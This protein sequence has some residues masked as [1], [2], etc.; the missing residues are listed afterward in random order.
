MSAAMPESEVREQAQAGSEPPTDHVE[1]AAPRALAP[2][3]PAEALARRVWDEDGMLDPERLAAVEAELI[4][5]KA[6]ATLAG[7]LASAAERASDPE[8]G[9]RT[10]T[11]AGHM[12][13]DDVKDPRRGAAL[14]QRV[15]ASDPLAPEAL[16]GLVRACLAD[17]RHEEAADVMERLVQALPD[18]EKVPVLVELAD[19]AARLDQVDRAL[20]A[21]RF[22]YELDPSRWD[23]LERARG[24]FEAEGR[25]EDAQQV[26]DDQT[27]AL[28]GDE[29]LESPEVLAGRV[30]EV[31]E[32]AEGAPEGS[33]QVEVGAMVSRLAA[34]YHGLGEALL[35]SAL[36]H[37]LAEIC[38]LTARSLGDEAALSLLDELASLRK[39]WEAR[40]TALRDRGFEAPQKQKAA[41]LYL[42]AAELFARYGQDALRADEYL[43]RCLILVP[44]YPPALR[45]LEAVHRGQGR[46]G[47]LVKRLNGMAAQVKDP[48][49]RADILLRVAQLTEAGLAEGEAPEP[50]QIEA[51]VNAYRRLLAHQPGHREAVA[52]L[53]DILSE[54]QRPADLA[55]VLEGHLAALSEPYQKVRVHLEL[56]RIYA[57]Q[58]GDSGRARN[59]FEAVLSLRPRDFV[60][61]SALRA[62]YKDAREAPLLLGVQKVL[63]E[64]CPD[65]FSRLELLAEMAE[66][67]E[68][69][70]PDEAFSVARAAFEL[71]P[72]ANGARARLEA[73]AEKLGRF[74]ALAETFASA[75][76]RRAGP[77]AEALWM[78]AGRLFDSKLPRPQDAIR[79]FRE[80][81]RENQGNAEATEA[82]ERL[83]RQQDDPEALVE[84]LR[85]QLAGSEDPEQQRI[86]RSKVGEVLAGRLGDLEGAIECFEAV[87]A[88]APDDP[89]ALAS[90]DDL[91]G[92][93]ERY[94]A[95]AQILDRRAQLADSDAERAE[96]LCRRAKLFDE[97]L[98]D[99]EKAVELYLEVLEAHPDHG[100]PVPA[101]ADLLERGV[102]RAPIAAALEPA[103][104]RR[105]QPDR[106]LVM[107]EVQLEGV[108]G[109]ARA[110][111]A[112]KAARVAE[113]R[114]DDR[115][116]ALT[117]L[118]TAVEVAASDEA[119][120]DR[121]IEVARAEA[122]PEEAAQALARGLD[123]GV[124][125]G[126]VKSR[127]AG[128]LAELLE[129]D[130]SDLDGAI[131]RYRE[132][133][134]ADGSNAS[135]IA[136]LERLLGAEAR[137]AELAELLEQRIAATD[138]PAAKVQLGLSV[139]GL[140]DEHLDDREGAIAALEAVLLVAPEDATALGR[141]A[142]LLEAAGHHRKLVGVLDRLR[143]GSADPELRAQSE[144]RAGDVLRAN[145]S[146][147]AEALARY[148]RALALSPN[149]AAAV[150]GLEALLDNEAHRTKAG[151]L[152][153]P[154]YEAAERWPD[155]VLAL[156]SQLAGRVDKAERASLFS[157][158]A[159]IEAEKLDQASSAFETLSRA[160]REGLL[161]EAQADRMA[162]LAQQS[163]K[164]RE[165]ARLYEDARP[166]H[167]D[168]AG[169]LRALARLYDG[170]AADPAKAR[171][172]Y[173]A[174]LEV[175]PGDAEALEALERLTAAGD[176]PAELGRVLEKRAEA[177]EA[178]PDRVTF[179]KR[180]AAIYEEAAEDIDAAIR[181][182]EA[183]RAVAPDDVGA[184]SEL[185]RFY[186]ARGDAEALEGVLGALVERT[187][188]PR[189]AANLLVRRA[190]ARKAQ[191]D[192][193]G[194]IEDLSAALAALPE[195]ADARAGLEDLLG[196]DAAPRAAL[197]LE[198][199][200]RAAGDWSR[201]VDAYEILV[202]SSEEPAE[203]VERLVA[204]RSIYEERL[205]QPAKAF[206]AAA[207]AYRQ[208]PA[209]E[210]LLAGL[211]RLG[212]MSGSVES[213]IAVL[214]DQAEE[215]PFVSEERAGLRLRVA[216]YVETLLQDRGRAVDAY[217]RALEE[218]PDSVAALEALERIYAK[219]GQHRELV[220]VLRKMAGILEDPARQ[221]ERL[222]L[223]ARIL[224]EQ[225]G[226][227]AQAA[228]LYEQVIMIEPG[229]GDALARL[230]A[231]YSQARAN[232]DLGRVLRLRIG[233]A[234]GAAQAAL[235]L[236]LGQ[237]SLAALDDPRGALEAYAGVL[238]IGEDV[239]QGAFDGAMY[240]LD[241]LI[242][243]VKDAN[244]ELAAE[245]A[246][247][248]EP[249]WAAK[250]QLAKVVG[251]K[252][253]QV[254]AAQDASTRKG[255]LV[256]IADL[257]DGQL[258]QAELAF[259]ALTRAYGEHP[260]DA[261]LVDRLEGLAERA[262]T[263]EELA[264]LFGHALPSIEDEALALRLAR[265][266]AHIYDQDL[267]R[268]DLAVPYYNWVLRLEPS[269]QGALAALE[270]I[271]HQQQDAAKLVDVYRG[272]LRA[273]EAP[274]TRKDLYGRIA[275]LLDSELQ[276]TDGAF[277]AYRAMLEV[278]PKDR[279]VLKRMAALC[280]RSDRFDELAAVLAKE[281]ELAE[282]SDDRAQVLLRLATVQRDRLEDPVSAVDTY[283]EVLGL[284][285]DDPGAISGL[286]AIVKSAG[287]GRADAAR[288]LA[289]VYK[290]TG[291]I[292]EYVDCLQLLVDASGDPMEKRDLLVEISE[293]YESRLGRPE[294]AF[295]YAQRALH[296]D[297]SHGAVRARLERLATENGQVEELAAF[298]LDEVEA[299]ED[300]ELALGLRRR[301][302]EIYDHE[303]GDVPRA[304]AEYGR[305]LDVAPG[306]R[307]SLMALERLY[308]AAGSFGAL[309]DVYRRR[310]AQSEDEEARAELLRQFARLQA[311][312]LGDA[313][314]AIASLRRLLELEPNDLEA[315]VK[316][317][318]LCKQQGRASE[319][320][321]VL[322]RVIETAEERSPVRLD[323]QLEL[324]RLKLDKLGDVAGAE[325]L[326]SAVLGEDPEH[327]ATR[328]LLQERFEDAVAE[329]DAARA[330]AFGG[331]LADALR[332]TED[333]QGLISVL[334]MRAEIMPRAPDRV[335]LEREVAEVYEQKLDQPELAFTTLAR[336]FAESPGLEEV[337]D[338][339]DRLA[340]RLLSY[341][342]L[343]DILQAGLPNAHD[344]E[345]AQ[346]IHRR[347]AQVLDEKLADKERAAEAW[348]VVLS[349]APMDAEGLA[350][351]DRLSEALGRWAAVA[352]VL[353]KRVE[354][355]EDGDARH[356]LCLRLGAVWDERLSEPEEALAWYRRARAEK[357]RDKEAL[358]ALSRLL[359]PEQHAQELFA[360]LE[361]LD[362]QAPDPRT[363]ARLKVRMADLAKGPL[364][365]AAEAV[366]LL[367]AVLLIDETNSKA[368]EGLE[369]LYEA[370]GHWT[371][372]AAL[373]ELQLE[374]AREEKEVVRLQRK[375][376]LIKGTRLGSV[377]EAVRSWSEILKRN[378]N[379]VEAL[380][381]LR[382]IYREAGRWEDLVA[383]LR[384]LVPLQLDAAGVKE[385][386]FELA[387]VFFEHLGD[388]DEAIESAKRVLDVEPHTASELMALEEILVRCGAYGE[389]VR[390]MNYRAEQAEG[391]GEKIEILFDIARVYEEK[392]GRLVGAAQAYEQV[393]ELEKTSTKAY[394]ALAGIYE[395]NGDYRRLVELYNRRL[396]V[397]EEAQAR[398]KLLFSI[399][400]IQERW[401]GHPELA[402]S[403]A[404]RAFGEEGAVEEAQRLAERLAEE[405]SNWEILAEV[406]EEQIEQV[407][408]SRAVQL[409]QRLAEI[410]LEKL[411]EPDEAEKQ[412]EMVLSMRPE[413]DS[414]RETLIRLFSEQER[415]SELIA[416]LTDKVELST[417]LEE[418]KHLFRRI[419]EIEETK[420]G[421]VEAAISSTKRV[422]DLDPEDDRALLE[423]SRIFRAHDKHHPLLNVLSRLLERAEDDATRVRL[424]MDVAAVWETGIED[425]D[426]A[427]EHYKDVLAL[428]AEHVPALKALE[429]LYT[430]L[431]RWIELVDVYERQVGLTTDS[432]EAIGLLTKIANIWE[433]QFRD[434]EGS[435][436]TLIR[437][438]EIDPEHLPTV[439]S[440]E[441]IWREAED[442]EHLIEAK[443]RHVELTKDPQEVVALQLE[444]GD[445]QL[446]YLERSDE[447]EQA[448][449]AALAKDPGSKAA[450]HALGQLY[451]K[452]GN[453]FN[454]LEM[455]SREAGLLG[456][457]PEAVEIHHRMGKINEEMLMDADAAKA[458]YARAL[459]IEPGYAPSIRAL[460]RMNEAEG[461]YEEVANLLAQEAQYSVDLEEQS[462]LY[463][464]SADLSLEH[465]DDEDQAIRLYDK[466]LEADPYFVPA[467]RIQGD[468]L[469]SREEW[470]Q[471]ESLLSRL[472]GRLD[473][474]ADAEELCRQYYRLAYIAE[475]LGDDHQ[476]LK[477]YLASYEIDSSY[478]PTLEGLGAALLR[479]E[480]WEDAQRIFQTILIQH[481][482]SLT[483]AEVVDLHWQIGELAA[484][485]S[486]LDKANKSFAK[487]L[488]LDPS[489]GPTL[490]ASAH[491]AERLED[492]EDAYDHRERLI[493]LLFG[494]ERFET[495]VEQAK[496]CEEKI[497]EPYRAIDAYM[498]ARRERPDDEQVLR[499]LAR[500]FDETGQVAQ[501]IEVLNDLG[502]VLAE[503][504]ERRDVYTQLADLHY[505]PEKNPKGAVTALNN[506]LDLDPMYI[507][508]FQR[509]EQIL[510]E[511]RDWRALEEN[512]HRM[513][514]RMPKEQ[515]KARLVL[516][517]SIGDL[518]AKVLKD[519]DGARVA[520]EVVLNKLDP[521]AHDVALELAE[522]Y[523]KKR[524]TAPKAITL[525]HRVL[526]KVEDPA[527]PARRLFELYHALGQLDRAFCALGALV[528]MRAATEDEVK[529]Y[530]LLL[531][532]A[533]P[534]P[535][536]SLSD[537]LWRSQVLHPHC[538]NGL[539]DILSVLYRG[540]PDM[541]AEPQQALRLGRRERIEVDGK[542]KSKRAGLR[543]F[544][545]WRRLDAAL[546][547]GPMDHYHRAGITQAPRMYPGS[548]PVLFAGEQHEVFKT[549]PP[550]LLAWTL[551]RQMASARPELAPLRALGAPDEVGAAIEA[552]IRLF[553]PEGS[554]V[555]LNL[556]PERIKAWQQAIPKNLSDRALKALREPVS[557]VIQKKDMKRMRRFL[558]GCEHS[559]SRAALLM[560]GD[561]AAAERGLGDSDLL[562]DVSFR[563]RVR[564]LML[565]TLS[566]DHFQLRE[567]LGLAIPA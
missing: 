354:L 14:L 493:G 236:R 400:D 148:E 476:A 89:S 41:E 557:A 35:S 154:C 292:A 280:E 445:I 455:L 361:A 344:S 119:L 252:E 232:E 270:R 295:T 178:D 140:R 320:S 424:R 137:Y 33:P 299:I 500:L 456:A 125:D 487:A 94:E 538:R 72:E 262:D 432:E 451:E 315:L 316:L 532:K 107:L 457:Q 333:W 237:L 263:Q 120:V 192:L 412:L 206:E 317:A 109:A 182:M 337:R 248:V 168:P 57:E 139:A 520:Y 12:Y 207:R 483:D 217:R 144:V 501:A 548:T 258:E 106:Q 203:R 115:G 482:A 67:A 194:S 177:A 265:R 97:R 114:L 510:Y 511:T 87:R 48:S 465:F 47:D 135:A 202:A 278:D 402:F 490:L 126:A 449:G 492:W 250:G 221:A 370:Q 348:Q 256:E 318:D 74:Q 279:S 27:R 105:G 433:E 545:V 499:A 216:R 98:S 189:T 18:P 90:L 334:R 306:D 266:T 214:E 80:A 561:V 553:L 86:L 378:P 547:A 413:A 40:A 399:I 305:V 70:S 29:A 530:S 45:Y 290:N 497:R 184:L 78:A 118:L 267:S 297:P 213:L 522:L 386:R 181:V 225:L 514:K 351:L 65:L 543:Y 534:W 383:T 241:D 302:A 51:V 160:F 541:F 222:V 387:E 539:S 565:F 495:L 300:H 21:L 523:A 369:E 506:A 158:I 310:I 180:A 357:P 208:M 304:I 373:L 46:E 437:V 436:K 96:L 394:E 498:E 362:E 435:A 329:D 156:E 164:A 172:T 286:A 546:Y 130:L 422:L 268:G 155:L 328:E 485:L 61:A 453:W 491:L 239:A 558:E 392:V 143:D 454:A 517:R 108:E 396:E 174:L 20:Y 179:L 93:A 234:E 311:D 261:D 508:A 416:Q 507:A 254:A 81:L 477:R 358:L 138:D 528:L 104:G 191:G 313:P 341:D 122:R 204:I 215:L 356:E 54:Q 389:A 128:A 38:L 382:Q 338:G 44:G 478:L 52:R 314:G 418:K 9:R 294:H 552:A 153:A 374:R 285:K 165:L 76:S 560:A 15:L 84:M 83:L 275:A 479:A 244:P 36:F 494:D 308:R 496:L 95:Q 368:L 405:T 425:V 255:L 147:P 102:A 301:V 196:S 149:H 385:V 276:D 197:A 296:E 10:L 440:L 504:R 563:A 112:Q 123:A 32:A 288:V 525:Y 562:V 411:E 231:L 50:E 431:E 224:D 467:L 360:V 209:N 509:I 121:A 274:E 281:T 233:R 249:R 42:Q 85:A 381:A 8:I 486:Q 245:A 17:E 390:V 161:D 474:A 151:L 464:R 195:H 518:Y 323:A 359:D 468:L 419:A 23:V 243:T 220:E 462:E 24:I 60:A 91:Y 198:P 397:T 257:Y 13:V 3:A 339:L 554:G 199:V 171:A 461:R 340:D 377:D 240:G 335:P 408:V 519:D 322:E 406:Y 326:F 466:A 131:A 5:Q 303:L 391:R 132:A 564:E 284:R 141:L 427:V 37:D 146:D 7:L 441:R 428:D 133:L 401:L 371:D 190:G 1:D 11:R 327:E 448:Y 58:L 447:A 247:L 187:E 521:E 298:Y 452:S 458:A 439:K 63:L 463:A 166:T 19:V 64:H 289:P 271:H 103:Y 30:Q 230:D 242:E 55:A 152:L 343:V 162:A 157:R 332:R 459:D 253:T 183:A 469:F 228:H 282:Q 559:A 526:D 293:S 472:V 415:W 116:R 407:G 515:R 66:V 287:A 145:L 226:D 480:R 470:E 505:G 101:L 533:P 489:H 173:E 186:D 68:E 379:D 417:E 331:L 73:L 291:A 312:E 39:D 264:E 319:L 53:T 113:T 471:A 524:E 513:I 350:A 223:A 117:H 92:R 363:S 193:G 529:A 75:A 555:D 325:A 229:H 169:L 367:R 421:D 395:R 88:A 450:T 110:E 503:P 355:A 364:A 142:G 77:S 59:H 542:G 544:D 388:K 16:A 79:A 551:A 283:A 212:K 134:D 219:A 205:G 176:D 345:L 69:V 556:D 269:D 536:R 347:R 475:K 246:R 540:A 423:L 260:N 307:E 550:R 56:G 43:D 159:E 6:W 136:A 429:R 111:I 372:L 512:Y 185:A 25:Y 342:E 31:F 127:V 100:T 251:A 443:E 442:W 353:E 414:A 535:T 426:Q 376:G 481:R 210:D 549:M 527:K 235:R 238:E 567:K 330:E 336:V 167:A 438:L 175:A 420:L 446:R 273:A 346:W 71:D 49:V 375:L 62:L 324:G 82:L 430:Q 403:A 150:R 227:R 188:E 259:L 2:A 26:L 218:R 22:A 384:K 272:M 444:I 410:Y 484:R 531:K 473:R 349:T 434:L 129:R 537:N 34:A 201:L 566:E 502:Q 488:D 460:R 170:A 352:D 404:C 409:R 4:A 124:D 309:A 28:L 200:Y 366:D 277:A 321:D 163:G 393:L 398:R 365:K 99:P 380:G 211:E 516:W